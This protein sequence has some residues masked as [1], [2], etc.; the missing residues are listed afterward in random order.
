M[1]EVSD[2]RGEIT[3]QPG[4]AGA[5][6]AYEIL[7]QLGIEWAL[8]QPS[9]RSWIDREPYFRQ[10]T[11]DAFYFVLDQWRA[12]KPLDTRPSSVEKAI[13]GRLGEGA[14]EMMNHWDLS[15]LVQQM[16]LLGTWLSAPA[17]LAEELEVSGFGAHPELLQLL[18]HLE[19]LLD[20][21]TRA[22]N[23]DFYGRPI[24]PKPRPTA[25]SDLA[26]RGTAAG[27]ESVPA[28]ATPSLGE[29]DNWEARLS[30]A[31]LSLHIVVDEL[32]LLPRVPAWAAVCRYRRMLDIRGDYAE[33]AQHHTAL[34]RFA[35][36]LS[37]GHDALE[38]ALYVATTLQAAFGGEAADHLRRAAASDL[39]LADGAAA[40][41]Q[42][43]GGE[44][45]QPD[46]VTAALPL[47]APAP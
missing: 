44:A 7:L 26:P 20:P 5:L 36:T 6:Y 8:A 28:E 9:L 30:E 17:R 31:G 21:K 23:F 45:A 14:V 12:T 4:E 42:A 33:R 29:I 16:E 10:I 46:A 1:I 25:D 40:L 41:R 24:G 47:W 2:G 13:A 22:W 35:R 37:R 11:Y 15:L 27:P 32:G 19:P 38:D 18:E 39:P 34:R 3:L 43:L